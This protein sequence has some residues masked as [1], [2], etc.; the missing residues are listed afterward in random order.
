MIANSGVLG[1]LVAAMMVPKLAL[2]LPLAR[3]HASEA[4]ALRWFSPDARTEAAGICHR[5]AP[6]DGAV[7]TPMVKSCCAR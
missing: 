6:R 2:V 3:R 4:I 7:G 5:P 1:V